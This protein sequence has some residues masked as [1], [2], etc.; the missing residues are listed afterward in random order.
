MLRVLVASALVGTV[1]A[2]KVRERYNTLFKVC[3]EVG[4]C[5]STPN[6]PGIYNSCM[7]KLKAGDLTAECLDAMA[8]AFP[9]NKEFQPSSAP[10]SAMVPTTSV[11][12]GGCTNHE[13]SEFWR[14]LAKNEQCEIPMCNKPICYKCT[15]SPCL[16]GFDTCGEFKQI[17]TEQPC[18]DENSEE[19]DDVSGFEWTAGP[20]VACPEDC[21]QVDQE[22]GSWMCTKVA[23]CGNFTVADKYC[24]DAKPKNAPCSCSKT[25]A[26]EM[27]CGYDVVKDDVGVIKA[28]N[29]TSSGWD[30]IDV[31]YAWDQGTDE[32]K[33]TI[34]CNGPCGMADTTTDDNGQ[35]R[36]ADSY[37]FQSTGD[38]LGTESMAVLFTEGFLSATASARKPKKVVVGVPIVYPGSEFENGQFMD[39]DN[40]DFY[41]FKTTG[42]ANSKW[43][44][45][46][47]T[48]DFKMSER[49]VAV[50]KVP[51]WRTKPESPLFE[52]TIPKFS[53]YFTDGANSIG[54]MAYAGSQTDGGIGEDKAF[55]ELKKCKQVRVC[56]VCPTQ[57][58]LGESNLGMPMYKTECKYEGEWE[59][60]D[61]TECTCDA[62]ACCGTWQPECPPEEERGCGLQAETIEPTAWRCI[63]ANQTVNAT[64]CPDTKP[65]DTCEL[66]ATEGCTCSKMGD[67]KT[68]TYFQEVLEVGVSDCDTCTKRNEAA[69]VELSDNNCTEVCGI[70]GDKVVGTD[71]YECKNG[72]KTVA[73]EMCQQNF[74][75]SEGVSCNETEACDPADADDLDDGYSAI[76]TTHTGALW[77]FNTDYKPSQEQLEH[78]VFYAICVE[79]KECS[80]DVEAHTSCADKGLDDVIGGFRG[81][82]GPMCYYDNGQD[83][84][85]PVKYDQNKTGMEI[86]YAE[87]HLDGDDFS[88]EVF[89]DGHCGDADGD[90]KDGTPSEDKPPSDMELDAGE[91]FFRFNSTE[92]ISIA[93]D[94]NDSGV[95]KYIVGV[96]S[97]GSAADKCYL[98]KYRDTNAQANMYTTDL[99]TS[100]GEEDIHSRFQGH[101]PNDRMLDEDVIALETVE[102]ECTIGKSVKIFIKNFVGLGKSP[103]SATDSAGDADKV[104]VEEDEDWTKDIDPSR[105]LRLHIFLGSQNDAGIGEDHLSIVYRQPQCEWT[106]VCPE[107][108]CGHEEKLPQMPTCH[109]VGHP[110]YI[111]PQSCC[112]EPVSDCPATGGACDECCWKVAECGVSVDCECKDSS[113]VF[114]ESTDDKCTYMPKPT[115]FDKCDH[116][117]Q[118]VVPSCAPC[119]DE[120][121]QDRK[122]HVWCQEVISGKMVADDSCKAADK[123]STIAAACERDE[124]E[125][126]CAEDCDGRGPAAPTP[127]LDLRLL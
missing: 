41:I 102:V 92:S 72:D 82:Q 91:D 9:N 86:L 50:G 14:F 48:R 100:D 56:P 31:K 96:P 65:D 25:D 2:Q 23:E 26:C 17:C 71:V 24:P 37:I 104:K 107:L 115:D 93:I 15:E 54:A 114:A 73:S 76:T 46:R 10:V 13:I 64:L 87:V 3:G 116:K 101:S 113:G 22:G 120:E 110:D 34:T 7:S 59:A 83:V 112:K 60:K 6:K 27:S 66:K 63:V 44:P 127:D 75:S 88:V 80:G 36:L 57:C 16:A 81:Y 124:D 97:T 108:G 28:E 119:M 51:Q 47:I 74:P 12:E 121:P 33:M 29:Q 111:M 45:N 35:Y 77:K 4:D 30:I 42:V 106:Q 78:T 94:P 55:C 58:G 90:G 70:K 49:G 52:F 85:I 67:E 84:G 53:T 105:A 79:E 95:Y 68:G 40:R 122:V 61:E 32:M 62:T 89:C 69:W 20:C 118:T 109:L 123:P 103:P 18:C 125:K 99:Y 117:W 11:N 19:C 21:G 8:V 98:S 5:K 38:L 126:C 39:R 1:A 43:I